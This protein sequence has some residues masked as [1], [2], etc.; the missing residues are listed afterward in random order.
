MHVRSVEDRA[1]A[2]IDRAREELKA[3]RNT[4]TQLERTSQ[5]AR[6]AAAQ[7][8]RE[9]VAQLRAA[10]RE[11]SAQRA[12]AEALETQL[13][14]LGN[15]SPSSAPPARRGSSRKKT[16]SSDPLAELREDFEALVAKMQTPESHAAV[17]ALFAATGKELGAVAQAHAHDLKATDDVNRK[18]RSA[19]RLPRR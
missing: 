18:P 15:S 13:K 7:E 17:R 4:L 1:H 16:P 6:D 19:R 2:E 14:R 10:E 9:H 11:A 3:L 12:R 8:H 5:V